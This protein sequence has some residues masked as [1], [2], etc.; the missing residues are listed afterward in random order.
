[1]ASLLDVGGNLGFF[2]LA[3]AAHGRSSAVF[4]PSPANAGRLLASVRANG[5]ENFVHVHTLCA[6]AVS[7]ELCDIG[8]N[9]RN[10][11]GLRHVLRRGE[12]TASRPHDR[13]V[14]RGGQRVTVYRERATSM[15]VR[16]DDVW[17]SL[18]TQQVFLKLDVEGAECAVLRGMRQAL[19][20]SGAVVGALVEFDKSFG[21]CDELAR[22]AFAVLGSRHALTIHVNGEEEATPADELCRR[23]RGLPDGYHGTQIN[24]WFRG[25]RGRRSRLGGLRSFS[26]AG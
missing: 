17:P 21:C 16:L 11:G 14:P 25:Q 2:A 5:F 13:G 8:T 22:G 24:L 7:G 12:Q 10:Q 23:V 3:A 15:S 19:N 26:G 1:M 6:A 4:E 20:Q 18:P 9:W